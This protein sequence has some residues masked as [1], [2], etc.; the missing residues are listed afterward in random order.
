MAEFTCCSITTA[1]NP[2]CKALKGVRHTLGLR[3]P[4]LHDSKPG[5]ASTI[6]DG[7]VKDY[8]SSPKEGLVLKKVSHTADPLPL[9]NTST[10]KYQ[11]ASTRLQRTSGG[12]Q[13]RVSE[14]T[15]RQ[16]CMYKNASVFWPCSHFQ[17]GRAWLE[18]PL[19]RH[20]LDTYVCT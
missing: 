2:I 13:T 1:D 19:Q 8:H 16:G 5:R 18:I 3:L 15:V 9:Y 17:P 14:N 11:R 20:T 12:E 7:W 6:T 4:L 10:S